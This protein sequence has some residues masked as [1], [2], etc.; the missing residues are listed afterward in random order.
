VLTRR[1]PLALAIAGLAFGLCCSG[2]ASAPEASAAS[3]PPADPKVETMLR[4]FAAAIVARD[5][6]TAHGAVATDVR[7]TLPLAELEETIGHYRDGLPDDLETE[8]SVEPYDREGASIVPN[9]LRDRIT[10]EGSVQFKPKDEEQEGFSIIVWVMSEAGEPRLAH[11][12][13]GD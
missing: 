1:T 9:A 12:F 8:V 5:Y 10:A 7:G 4:G 13:V 3:A 11:F 6:A 2:P